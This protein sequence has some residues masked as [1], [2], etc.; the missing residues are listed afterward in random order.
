MGREKERKTY[1]PSTMTST[2][3]YP[4]TLGSP[5]IAT[6]IMAVRRRKRRN[7]AAILAQVDRDAIATL[8][9]QVSRSVA[10]TG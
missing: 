4:P 6:D 3:F 9:V 2:A 10:A 1:I 5:L 7:F 8:C